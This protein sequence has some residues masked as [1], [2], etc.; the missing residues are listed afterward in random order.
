[1]KPYELMRWL[2][3]WK[4]RTQMWAYTWFQVGVIWIKRDDE[5]DDRKSNVHINLRKCFLEDNWNFPL[6]NLIERKNVGLHN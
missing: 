4:L 2:N 1:L 3:K 5:D 6:K